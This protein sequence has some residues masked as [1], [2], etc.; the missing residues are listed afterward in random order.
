MTAMRDMHDMLLSGVPAGERENQV[1]RGGEGPDPREQLRRFVTWDKRW[2]NA[3][4]AVHPRRFVRA[5]ES[6]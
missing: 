2:S 6:R 4:S 1:R 5:G 3:G